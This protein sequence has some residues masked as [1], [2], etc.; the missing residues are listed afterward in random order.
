MP[1]TFD[2]GQF[3]L[4]WKH[5]GPCGKGKGGEDHGSAV[6]AT[7][8]GSGPPP[9]EP[10]PSKARNEDQGTGSSSGG[11]SKE[12]N[13]HAILAKEA[14][15][16]LWKTQLSARKQRIDELQLLIA[17]SDGQEKEMYQGDLLKLLKSRA[18]EMP[19]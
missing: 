11:H 7:S 17:A 18:P 10:K 4:T 16:E 3:F 15:I 13:F 19:K 12:G 14:N 9:P 1:S 8:G 5:L 2:G 6:F